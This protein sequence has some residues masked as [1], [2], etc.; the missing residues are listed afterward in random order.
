MSHSS[1][2]L[3]KTSRL[4]PLS[5]RKTVM[6]SALDIGSSKIVCVIARLK[7]D[8]MLSDH[9][10]RSH[11]VE[12]VGFGQHRALGVKNGA[13]VDLDAAEQAIRMAVDGAEKM[14]GLTIESLIV[15]LSSG[16]VASETY[17][18]SIAIGGHEVEDADISR[19][20][21]VGAAQ[22]IS[23]GR[24]VIH[25]MPVSYGLD[26]TPGILDPRG[27]VG[28]ELGVNMHVVTAETAAYRN[29]VVC[30]ERCHLHVDA[31]V[32]SPYAAAL[33]SLVADEMELGSAIIDMGGGTTSLAVMY[34]GRFIHGDVLPIGGNHVTSDIAQC[35]STPLG[36]AERLKT[37]HGS[38]L[39]CPSDERELLTYPHTGEEDEPAG[40]ITRAQLVSI[41]RPRV[42]ETLEII[43]DRLRQSGL[44]AV[45]GR[46]LVLTGGGA[47]LSGLNEVARRIF[48]KQVRIG[49]P[50]GINNLPETARRPCFSVIAGLAI[51]PQVAR[52][53]QFESRHSRRLNT[54]TGGYF[55]RM[56]AWFKDSF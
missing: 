5:P 6:V 17:A 47:E 14:S 11:A 33:S 26:H 43:R 18:A 32:V 50:L 28:E 8:E 15:N 36:Y 23:E 52:I 45:A 37:L 19:V 9:P 7:P 30:V 49:R 38:P 22:S 10:H 3:G 24:S 53:E 41:I 40:Q 13:I 42:E 35:L 46:C 16:R 39:P 4:K 25:A 34:R 56:G 20:L 54:G 12:I 1:S 48:G 2:Y 51:Y 44:E 31:V 55:A 21:Q 27:M 29:I